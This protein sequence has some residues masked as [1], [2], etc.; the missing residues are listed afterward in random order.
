MAQPDAATKT[1]SNSEI[2]ASVEAIGRLHHILKGV[3]GSLAL[4]KG[5]ARVLLDNA[6]ALPG[7]VPRDAA[8]AIARL[9]LEVAHRDGLTLDTLRAL[10]DAVPVPQ[11]RM[12]KACDAAQATG[13]R[14]A[15]PVGVPSAGEQEVFPR[16]PGLPDETPPACPG[17]GGD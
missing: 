2:L 4:A 8:V 7:G 11:A 3:D 12:R 15:P 14:P 5:F 6:H 16:V 1:A 10:V 17:P 13:P 9:R